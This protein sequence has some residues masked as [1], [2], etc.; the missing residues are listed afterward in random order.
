ML[1][2][3]MLLGTQSAAL[4]TFTFRDILGDGNS[5]GAVGYNAEDPFSPPEST[6]SFYNLTDNFTVPERKEVTVQL[7]I[8]IGW[9]VT[10]VGGMNPP[11]EIS[12]EPLGGAQLVR[13]N[14]RKWYRIL[15][16]VSFLVLLQ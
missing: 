3:E 6:L 4:C 16:D 11:Q 10:L 14:Y 8:P 12:W 9:V 5:W 7:E 15:G 13:D 2:K 1:G